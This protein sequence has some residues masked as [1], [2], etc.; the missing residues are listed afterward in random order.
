M[1][2]SHH[3]IARAFFVFSEDAPKVAEGEWVKSHAGWKPNG[4]VGGTE[5]QMNE[6]RWIVRVRHGKVMFRWKCCN[7]WP[8]AA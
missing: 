4:S 7:S 1:V 2:R 3:D 6:D 5:F 8:K